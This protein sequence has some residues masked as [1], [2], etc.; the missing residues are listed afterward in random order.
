MKKKQRHLKKQT[1]DEMLRNLFQ[2]LQGCWQIVGGANGKA[3]APVPLVHHTNVKGTI[4]VTAVCCHEQAA[5][6]QS[7]GHQ[8]NGPAT[9]E[10]D[11]P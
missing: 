5:L 9:E 6:S 8:A 2:W 3:P 4:H 7:T 11:G 1:I 10:R